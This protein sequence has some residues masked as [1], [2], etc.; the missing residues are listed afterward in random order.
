MCCDGENFYNF[1]ANRGLTR[2]EKKESGIWEHQL[3]NGS[4]EAKNL[5]FPTFLEHADNLYLRHEGA[6]DVP[7]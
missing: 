7:F 5:K 3:T 6:P 4:D 2:A 1:S